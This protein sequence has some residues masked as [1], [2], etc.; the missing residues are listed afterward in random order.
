MAAPKTIT[1]TNSIFTIS[2]PGL[3]ILNQQLQGYAADTA[4]TSENIQVTENLICVDAYKS[5]GYRPQL[6]VN[7]VQLQADSPSLIIFQTL[8]QAMK[9]IREIYY[10]DAVIELPSVQL[11]YALAQGTLENYHPIL[12]A[13]QVMQPVEFSINWGTVVVAPT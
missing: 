2:I 8:Y 6:I 12:D 5:S 9:A 1:S 11:T 7:N 13:A 3:G 10:I 4:F